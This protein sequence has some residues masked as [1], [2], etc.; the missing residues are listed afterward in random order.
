MPT[1]ERQNPEPAPLIIAHRGAS[2][3]APENTLVAFRLALAMGADGIE[4][5]VNLSSDGI[6]VVIHDRR[7]NRTTDRAALVSGCSAAELNCLDAGNWFVRRLAFRPRARKRVEEAFARYGEAGNQSKNHPLDFSDQ[8]VPTLEAVFCALAPAG[9]KRLYVELKGEAATKNELLH[10][11]LALIRYHRLERV[12]TL[13]SFDHPLIQQARAG[14]PEVR[15]AVTLPAARTALVSARSIASAVERAAANEAAL[16]YSLASRRVVAA[17]HERGIAVSVWTANN[18]VVM[19]RLIANGVD[20][21]M[22][23]YPDRLL[24]LL[25]SRPGPYA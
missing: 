23:N 3:L 8:A 5:D 13:L 1:T 25:T 12:V 7:L 2:G 6:P 22:T 19:R 15:A 16:H 21:S 20:A 18:R 14:A 10:A 24:G 9:V 11:T 17:L 4:M